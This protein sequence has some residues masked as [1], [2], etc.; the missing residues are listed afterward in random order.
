MG[1]NMW[2]VWD[3]RKFIEELKTCKT[4][5]GHYKVLEEHLLDLGFKNPDKILCS[6]I[7]TWKIEQG[8]R[9]GK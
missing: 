9:Y 3:I 1:N 5:I 7:L 8:A 4:S 2:D 6:P